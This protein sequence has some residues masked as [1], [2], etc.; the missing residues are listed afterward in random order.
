V[1]AQCPRAA[2][3][4][5]VEPTSL[6]RVDQQTFRFILRS[7]TQQS[8]Q[9]KI[10]LLR[11]V[12]FLKTLNDSDI[13]KMT[14]VMTPRVFQ[15]D[16]LLVKKGDHGDAFYVV[17]EGN[18]LVKDI[19]VGSTTYEDQTLGPG[20]YFGERALVT[21]DKRVANV[22]ALNKGVA[23]SIDR[24]TFE[25]AVGKMSKLVMKAQDTR[26][27]AGV[28]VFSKANMETRQ[29]A[30]LASII[31]DQ[32]YPRGHQILSEGS[33]T[34]SALYFVREGKVEVQWNGRADFVEPGGYFGDSLF[35]AEG[36]VISPCTATAMEDS[37][38]GVLTV[39]DCSGV[40]DL[41]ALPRDTR[42]DR[43]T[44][45]AFPVHLPTTSAKLEDLD[46]HTILGEG[47]FGQV[48]L[49]SERLPD[50]AR[51]PYALKI[52]SKK[53]LERVSSLV[54]LVQSREV[55]WF[56]IVLPSPVDC[57]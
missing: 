7:Q 40:L 13:E 32:A 6:F 22:I 4:V 19:C 25:K 23:F 10:S 43:V 3:V 24:E 37:V 29:L 30:A 5:A 28:K 9:E 31:V 1:V 55:L 54:L 36:S 21:G 18:V 38:C 41:C 26:R 51:R 17:A 33:R 34:L 53:D 42:A 2:T 46:R 50:G 15:K 8:E 11:N 44:S 47:T 14:R 39:N 16:D 27:L 45:P 49:V 48:H 52:Q 57:R 20:D 12:D 56:L 35:V